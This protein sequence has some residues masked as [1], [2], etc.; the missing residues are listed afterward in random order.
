MWRKVN[1]VLSVSMSKIAM[2]CSGVQTVPIAVTDICSKTA[3]T[4]SIVLDDVIWIEKSFIF[5]IKMLVKKSTGILWKC[6]CL[7]PEKIGNLSGRTP[8]LSGRL[9][10][11]PLCMVFLTKIFS[12]ISS[13]THRMCGSDLKSKM[14]KISKIVSLWVALTPLM[15][16]SC[17]VTQNGIT[18]RLLFLLMLR[19][20][21]FRAQL[22]GAGMCIIL[23]VVWM[24]RIVLLVPVFIHTSTIAYSINL[25]L[26]QNTNPFAVQSLTIWDRQVSGESFSRTNSRH[27]VT[28]K[29]LHKNISLWLNLKYEPSDGIGM[30][31]NLNHLKVLQLPLFLFLN[32][33]R[34][35]SDMTLLKKTLI[36]FWIE[37]YSVKSLENLSRL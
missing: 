30:L 26:S 1:S 6:I 15:T 25:I 14:H 13:I 19:M 23:I 31:K 22:W 33:V 36:R 29:P 21:L 20:S 32:T 3:T 5:L 35:K 37:S 4:V 7:L 9:L 34:N 2:E 28:M 17:L 24:W 10:C 11:N 12:E 16:V 18:T 8:Y 27:L